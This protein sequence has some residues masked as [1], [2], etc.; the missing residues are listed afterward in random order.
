MLTRLAQLQQHRSADLDRYQRTLDYLLTAETE[1]GQ[2]IDEIRA[3]IAQHS[4]KGEVLKKEARALRDSRRINI[5]IN[6]PTEK[7]IRKGKGREFERDSMSPIDLDIDLNDDEDVEDRGLPKTPVGED[8]RVKRMALLGRLRECLIVLHRVKFLQGDVYHVLG[9]SYSEKEDAAYADAESLRKD[10]LKCEF[11]MHI[12]RTGVDACDWLAT[13]EAANKAMRR[14]SVAATEKRVTERVLQIPLPFMEG[15]GI[16]SAH[17]VSVTISTSVSNL[18]NFYN[19]LSSKKQMKSSKTCLT[20]NPLFSG[21][22]VPRLLDYLL[23]NLTL[24]ANKLMEKSTPV[25][26]TPRAR[27]RLTCKL[28]PHSSPIAGRQSLQN[29]HSSRRTRV[30]RKRR[31][32]PTL[33]LGQSSGCRRTWRF[34]TT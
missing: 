29:E 15:G 26:W 10:L 30:E 19:F 9:S 23:K 31:E 34:Q 27:P 20:N 24:P 21:S 32:R 7:D 3:T 11:V 17:L 18:L 33:P 6:Q 13:E 28:M 14:L 5:P 22:G 16:R 8:H 12:M 4:L 1:A 2:L 25:H